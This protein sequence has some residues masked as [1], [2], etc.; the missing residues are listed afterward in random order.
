MIQS[1]QDT[2]P[3][4]PAAPLAEVKPD[5]LTTPAAGWSS[6]ARTGNYI[7]TRTRYYAGLEEV[8]RAAPK[9]AARGP[10]F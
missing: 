1:W 3:Q 5:P 7:A 9:Q 8:Q 2:S 4:P 6:S 10:H